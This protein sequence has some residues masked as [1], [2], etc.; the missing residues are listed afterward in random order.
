MCE[1]IFS[2][3]LAVTFTRALSHSDTNGD[4]IKRLSVNVVST[5]SSIHPVSI[6]QMTVLALHLF[7]QHMAAV[8]IQ[9]ILLAAIRSWRRVK[10]PQ[11]QVPRL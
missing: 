2:V 11:V 1:T 7:V 6:K 10:I 3:N 8:Q 4:V 9:Y 5:G